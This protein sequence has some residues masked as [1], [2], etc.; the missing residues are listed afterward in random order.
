MLHTRFPG[1][2]RP[3]RNPMVYQ[4]QANL[5]QSKLFLSIDHTTPI[6]TNERQVQKHK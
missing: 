1:P 4:T 3:S 5:D 2:P 6:L